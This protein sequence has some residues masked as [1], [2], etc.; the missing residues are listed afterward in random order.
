MHICTLVNLDESES[1]ENPLRVWLTW[2]T[3]RLSTPSLF[4]AKLARY[5]A[6]RPSWRL[7][8]KFPSL[9]LPYLELE[10]P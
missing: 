8:Y 4:G 6:E 3:W 7:L 1:A 9:P 5:L 10:L 2:L